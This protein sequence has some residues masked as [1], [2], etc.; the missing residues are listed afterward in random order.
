[1]IGYLGVLLPGVDPR[2]SI[3]LEWGG[4]LVFGLLVGSFLNVCIYRIPRGLSVVAPRS[5]CPGCHLQIE[6]WE[7]VPILSYLI[8]R[9]RCRR[10]GLKI[11]LRYFLV[12]LTTGVLAAGLYLRLG[13]TREAALAFVFACAL[14]VVAY[15]DLD[16]FIIPD[17]ISLGGTLLFF[18]ASL[19][20]ESEADWGEAIVGIASGWTLGAPSSAAGW[21]DSLVGLATGGL[22]L[23]A[24]A[25]SYRKFTGRE[26]LGGGDV[27]L[28]AMIGAFFGAKGVVPS[29][30]VGSVLGSLTGVALMLLR[31]ADRRTALPFGPFLSVGALTY[32]FQPAGGLPPAWEW[33]W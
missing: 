10:C 11:P 31:Q 30:L 18:L 28:L 8:L 2:F 25:W 5:F 14:L 26:G 7:N 32:L 29:L 15:I 33:P 27:K 13:A 16:F 21:R 12:E 1:M 9:G 24:I 19:P 17:R 23:L 4:V 20:T 22:I 6:A 3:L